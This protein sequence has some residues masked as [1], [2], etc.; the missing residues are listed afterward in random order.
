M[1]RNRISIYDYPEHL[2][3]FF[4]DDSLVCQAEE[5]VGA[6]DGKWKNRKEKYGTWGAGARYKIRRSF[7]ESKWIETLNLNPAKNKVTKKLFSFKTKT[8]DRFQRERSKSNSFEHCV[9]RP[10]KKD[11]NA[12]TQ[13]TV[14]GIK[15]VAPP[16]PARRHFNGAST[17]N[18]GQYKPDNT[19]TSVYDY[20]GV[21]PKLRKKRAA[22]VPPGAP[23]DPDTENNQS[24]NQ[25][26]MHENG[27]QLNENCKVSVSSDI[28]LHDHGA[29]SSAD[30]KVDVHS[31]AIPDN[32]N[33]DQPN[34]NNKGNPSSDLHDDGNENQLNREMVSSEISTIETEVRELPRIIIE[35]CETHSQPLDAKE[36]FPK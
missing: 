20:Q 35:N 17:S 15:V 36:N 11:L 31:A 8:I 13:K 33:G 34:E 19:R 25:T 22:P 1:N 9:Q 16:L 12:Q 24:S 27:V 21:K 26:D 4:E 3:P 30:S 2:N 7:L 10:E 32:G 5:Q 18:Y 23:L 28:G 14:L 29:Q 6:D